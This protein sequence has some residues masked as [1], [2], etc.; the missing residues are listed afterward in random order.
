MFD[1]RSRRGFTL[2]EMLTTIAIIAVLAAILFPVFNRARESARQASC[3]SNM[4]QIYVAT[5]LYKQDYGEYPMLLLGVA[6]N[7]DG[8][9]FTGSGT[10]VPAAQMTRSFLYPR[11]VKSIETFRCPNNPNNNQVKPVNAVFPGTAGFSGTVSNGQAGIQYHNLGSGAP[12]FF[13][14]Y[15]SYDITSVPG[16]A[17]GSV[18]LA[19][20]RDWTGVTGRQDKPNQLKYRNPPADYTILTACN[21]HVTVG[22]SDRCPIVTLAGVAKTLDAKQVNQRGWNVLGQ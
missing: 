14:A 18:Q 20:A 12:L 11:F 19:Y 22:G 9:P 5:N 6:E 7:P 10:P 1:T 16:G 2:I 3:M 15:D 13:Y 21:Y 4:H 8:T 17:T